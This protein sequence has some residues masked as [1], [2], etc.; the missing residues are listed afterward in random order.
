[1]RCD[2]ELAYPSMASAPGVR[3]VLAERGRR[4]GLEHE[5]GSCQQTKRPLL[6]TCS[7]VALAVRIFRKGNGTGDSNPRSASMPSSAANSAFWTARRRFRRCDRPSGNGFPIL[8]CRA[9]GTPGGGSILR[10]CRKRLGIPV[11]R[12]PRQ[13][14]TR[15]PAGD[16]PTRDSR[17]GCGREPR[18]GCCR[19]R[20]VPRRK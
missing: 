2:Y 17:F 10:D 7:G 15:T 8:F 14:A 9:S 11:S 19:A 4:H 13:P 3:Q 6:S 16:A 18:P 1:M 20:P 12:P 5:H